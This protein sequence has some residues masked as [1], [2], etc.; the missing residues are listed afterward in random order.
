MEHL[1]KLLLIP[2]FPFQAWET[3]VRKWS[4]R[5][6]VSITSR[7][8]LPGVRL[9]SSVKQLSSPFLQRIPASGVQASERRKSVCLTA[10]VQAL[11]VRWRPPSVQLRGQEETRPLAPRGEFLGSTRP[12]MEHTEANKGGDSRTQVFGSQLQAERSPAITVGDKVI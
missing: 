1:A 9:L 5:S 8:P 11:Q 10:L 4:R 6:Q 7:R 12:S 2:N 3:S